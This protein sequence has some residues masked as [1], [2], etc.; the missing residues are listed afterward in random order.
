MYVRLQKHNSINVYLYGKWAHCSLYTKK[1]RKMKN[2]IK[3]INI[4][5][6][7]FIIKVPGVTQFEYP[8]YND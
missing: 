1:A 6:T 2:A 7:N 4:T 3:T 5:Y 8:W